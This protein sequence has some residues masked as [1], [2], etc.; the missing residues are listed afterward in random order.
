MGRRAS[1]VV[2]AV[3]TGFGFAVLMMS[4]LMSSVPALAKVPV[5]AISRVPGSQGDFPCICPG[6]LETCYNNGSE[7]ACGT[8]FFCS[9]CDCVIIDNYVCTN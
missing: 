9:A 5:S 6:W 2:S 8:A 4:C 3:S 1:L 7:Y